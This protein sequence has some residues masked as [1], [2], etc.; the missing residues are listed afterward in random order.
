MARWAA[1]R[2]VRTLY[3]GVDKFNGDFLNWKDQKCSTGFMTSELYPS[4]PL[5]Q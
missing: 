5:F 1:D 3:V 2:P 4:L